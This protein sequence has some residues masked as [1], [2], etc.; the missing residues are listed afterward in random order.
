MLYFCRNAPEDQGPVVIP[1]RSGVQSP[2]TSQVPAAIGSLPWRELGCVC[3]AG[4]GE[5]SRG[6]AE[7]GDQHPL[8][9]STAISSVLWNWITPNRCEWWTRHRVSG[10]RWCNWHFCIWF[11]WTH[12]PSLNI[13]I[14]WTAQPTLTTKCIH[15]WGFV[16][17]FLLMYNSLVKVFTPAVV[18]EAF[19]SFVY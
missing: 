2:R 7:P 6:V 18:L 12:I 13:G 5:N 15:W 8:P 3:S 10:F 4:A 17:G 11:P 16:G 14:L 19:D 9:E 1:L